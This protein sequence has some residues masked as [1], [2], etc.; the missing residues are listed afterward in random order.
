ME[1]HYTHTLSPLHLKHRDHYFSIWG[2]ILCFSGCESI[3]FWIQSV[4]AP[5]VLKKLPPSFL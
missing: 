3:Y 2:S 1:I 4:M 5:I